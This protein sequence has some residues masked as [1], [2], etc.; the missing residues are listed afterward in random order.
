MAD[1]FSLLDGHKAG[2][3]GDNGVLFADV[4]DVILALPL[5]N[6]VL[7]LVRVQGALS[8]VPDHCLGCQVV[9]GLWRGG[10]GDR[11]S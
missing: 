8:P 11:I 5:D 10:G 7:G 9:Q 6:L 1:L 2:E 4:D 3:L